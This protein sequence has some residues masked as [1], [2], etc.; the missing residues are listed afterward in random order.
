[1]PGQ[2]LAC[3]ASKKPPERALRKAKKLCAMCVGDIAALWQPVTQ[4][5]SQLNAAL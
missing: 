5:S 1:M 2:G 4:I 3:I